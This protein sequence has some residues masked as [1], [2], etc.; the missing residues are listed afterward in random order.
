[1]KNY[2]D[3]IYPTPITPLAAYL[4]TLGFKQPEMDFSNPSQVVFLFKNDTKALEEAVF[5]YRTA[6]AEGNIVLFYE[7]YKKL[8]DRINRGY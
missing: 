7:N 6:K 8:L 3:D 1:M 4:I 2:P 5:A